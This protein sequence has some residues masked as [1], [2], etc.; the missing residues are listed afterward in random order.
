M[1]DGVDGG[2]AKLVGRTPAPVYLKR[3]KLSK[4]APLVF[5]LSMLKKLNFPNTFRTNENNSQLTYLFGSGI[6]FTQCLS[7]TN[8]IIMSSSSA[9][10]VA[11]Y[12]LTC[13]LSRVSIYTNDK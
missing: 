11:F 6:I 3:N 4:L 12:C 5:S 13:P 10:F 8:I 2:G 9:I 7:L 1:K